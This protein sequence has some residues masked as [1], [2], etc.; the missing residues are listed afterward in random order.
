MTIWLSLSTFLICSACSLWSVM[1]QPK[2]GHPI[3]KPG[4]VN[5][6]RWHVIS[7]ENS[8]AMP[9]SSTGRLHF[10]SESIEELHSFS[11]ISKDLYYVNVQ[12][13]EHRKLS[14]IDR[15]PMPCPDCLVHQPATLLFSPQHFFQMWIHDVL[16]EKTH[17]HVR[18]NHELCKTWVSVPCTIGLRAE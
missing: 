1:A 5:T 2:V 15:I 10:W 6:R 8:T 18:K 13:K 14:P 16:Q 3:R 11:W 4:V 7:R 12:E 9:T 17:P